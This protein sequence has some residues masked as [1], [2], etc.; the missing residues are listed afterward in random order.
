VRAQCIFTTHTPVEAGHDR[1]AY[2]DVT[3]LLGDFLAV[4]QLRLI[5]GPDRLNMTQLAL[6]LSGFV[7]GVARRHGET[8]RRMY[9]AYRI[10]DITNGVH[11]PTWTHPALARLYDGIAPGWRHA[12]EELANADQLGE[13]DV[14][15]AHQAAKAELLA[16]IERRCG[17]RMQADRPLIAYARRMTGYKRPDLIFADLERLRQINRR[18]PF[19]VVVRARRIP[20]TTAARR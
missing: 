5:A 19:Q 1:F 10:R 13:A 7:N 2:E 4:D 17:V 16:L 11:G 14:W 3:R 8:A 18:T 12:P 20:A 9:P 6:N 15:D